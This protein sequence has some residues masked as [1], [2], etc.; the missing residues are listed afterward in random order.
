MLPATFASLE[1]NCHIPLSLQS[2]A[3]TANQQ[4][5][6]YRELS[7]IPSLTSQEFPLNLVPDDS[8]IIARFSVP[9]HLLLFPRQGISSE[10]EKSG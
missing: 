6:N 4:I 10:H 9:I 5:S 8:P 7:K 1:K 2:M 3:S